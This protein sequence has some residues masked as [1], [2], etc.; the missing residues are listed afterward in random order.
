MSKVVL[1]FATKTDIELGLSEAEFDSTKDAWYRAFVQPAS[2]TIIE[3][4]SK[5]LQ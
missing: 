3:I 5:Y 2:R 4:Q 1:F